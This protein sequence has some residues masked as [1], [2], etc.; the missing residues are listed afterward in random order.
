MD[1]IILLQHTIDSERI[2]SIQSQGGRRFPGFCRATPQAQEPSSA[3]KDFVNTYTQG[4]E[5]VCP[6]SRQAPQS[7]GIIGD[8]FSALIWAAEHLN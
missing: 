8:G 4:G 2:L 1:V 3:H 5:S 7:A 6:G